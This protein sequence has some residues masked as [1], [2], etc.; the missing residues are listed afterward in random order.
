MSTPNEPHIAVIGD[1]KALAWVLTDQRIAFPE[2]RYKNLFPSLRKGDVLYLYTTRGCFKNPS[3]DRGRIIG[4]AVATTDMALNDDPVAFRDRELPYELG[5]KIESLAPFGEGIDVSEHI[6]A[7]TSFPKPERWSVY[8]RRSLLA[9]TAKDA[10][11]F[12]KLLK[13]HEG[14]LNDNIGEYQL[15]ARIG[16]VGANEGVR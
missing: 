10:K 8:L 7:M 13:P 6:D 4:K 2:P 15:R 1:R 3:R 14:R 11:L 12:D 16:V 9:V 5:I